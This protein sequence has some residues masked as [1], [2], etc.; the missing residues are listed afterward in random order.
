M[1]V[2]VSNFQSIEDVRLNVSGFTLLVGESSQGKSATF[3][4]LQAAV[5][6]RFRAGQVRNGTE[7]AE[8]GIKF[9]DEEPVLKVVKPK[10]GSASMKL[11]D[12]VYSKLARTVPS[13]VSDLCNMESLTSDR[14][15]YSLNFH[16]QFEEPM[17]LAFSQQKVMELLSASEAL[18][19]LNLCKGALSDRRSENKGAFASLDAILGR[20]KEQYSGLSE[21]IKGVEGIVDRIRTLKAASEGV[22]EELNRIDDV[23]ELERAL[24]LDRERRSCCV[25]ICD[26]LREDVSSELDRVVSLID[27][28]VELDKMRVRHSKGSVYVGALRGIVEKRD[29]L[30]SVRGMLGRFD[31]LQLLLDSLDGMRKRRLECDKVVNGGICPICGNN[32][33]GCKDE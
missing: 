3:R 27:G 23:L 19:D 6:N 28:A 15:A 9:S 2:K 14:D 7:S 11:G 5:S 18:D 12:V 32:I 4:A 10:D 33:G 16:P 17:L 24:S 29:E 31:S 26:K 30:D 25:A 1:Q 13:E 20:L 8:I 21:R 22:S